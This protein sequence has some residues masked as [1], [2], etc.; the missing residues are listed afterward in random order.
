MGIASRWKH[1]TIHTSVSWLSRFHNKAGF[2]IHQPFHVDHMISKEVGALF[3]QTVYIDPLTQ[4]FKELVGLG[5]H[6]FEWSDDSKTHILPCGASIDSWRTY[7][8]WKL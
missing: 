3:S 2:H 4:L 6:A 1:S 5:K 7:F 8:W